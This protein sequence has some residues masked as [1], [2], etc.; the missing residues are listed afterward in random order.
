MLISI[1]PFKQMPY[2]TDREIEIYQCAVSDIYDVQCMHTLLKDLGS[3]AYVHC[4]VLKLHALEIAFYNC[5]KLI[6]I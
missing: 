4:T 3:L 1:N 5:T 6:Y 2:F